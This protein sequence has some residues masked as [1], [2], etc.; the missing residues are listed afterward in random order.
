MEIQL[1][2]RTFEINRIQSPMR[3]D[4]RLCQLIILTCVESLRCVGQGEI[5]LTLFAEI[6]YSEIARILLCLE[7][8]SSTS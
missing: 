3:E 4:Q 6:M 1:N 8:R 7:M 5:D 2:H